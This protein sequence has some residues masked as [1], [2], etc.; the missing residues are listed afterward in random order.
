MDFQKGDD[1]IMERPKSTA[2]EIKRLT[3]IEKAKISFY[4]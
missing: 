1:F 2:A 4:R 3:K